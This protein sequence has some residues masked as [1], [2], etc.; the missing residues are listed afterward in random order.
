MIYRI[1]ALLCLAVF[2]GIYGLKMLRQRRRGITTDQLGKGDKEPN[3]K[4]IELVTKVATITVVII[5]VLSIIFTDPKIYGEVRFTGAFCCL[6]GIGVFYTAVK[7]MGRSWRAGITDDKTKLVTSGI[8]RISRNPAFL[9]FDLVYFGI[10]LM[11][12]NFLLLIFS[13]FA[14]VMLHLQ[15]L[16]E[17]KHLEEKFGEEYIRYKE[18]TGRY[19]SA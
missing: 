13:V 2:Y 1:Y 16:N 19:F 11:F 8:F 4:T 6:V 14:G 17:E 12:F 3:V 9:G 18:K 7:T 10:L 5:E 15:I